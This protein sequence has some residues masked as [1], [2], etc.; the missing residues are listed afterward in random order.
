MEILQTI[1]TALTTPNEGL[2]RIIGIPLNFLEAYI[3]MILFTTI[4]NIESTSKRRLI[5]VLVFGLIGNISTFLIP[6][7]YKIFFTMILWAVL[8]YFILQASLLKSILSEVITLALTSVVDFICAHIFF[9]LFGITSNQIIVIPLYKLLVSITN[10]TIIFLL[11]LIIK[12]FKINI[13]VFD[14]M[15][16]KTKIL[17]VANTVLMIIVIAMQ[18]YIIDFYSD[19]MPTFITFI[20]IL[21]LIAYFAISV[22]SIINSSKLEIASRD[23]EGANL[24]IH[25]LRV[26]HD[27]VRTFKHDFDN[28]VNGIGGYVR[29]NDMEGL[30][31]YYDQ[32]LQDCNKTNNLYSLNPNVIN[33]PAI[34]NILATKYYVADELNVQINLD[35]FLDLNEIEKHMKIYE[36]TRIL[37][38]LLDNAIEAAKECDDKTINVTFRKEDVKHRLIVIIENTYNNKDVNIDEIFEKGI[39]SKQGNSGLGLW[40]IRQILKKNNNLNLFTTKDNKFFKQQFEI[41]Y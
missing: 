10:Y 25:S 34:Y 32:L 3:A 20:S 17:L 36:F 4:L 15:S 21:A 30:T 1:W 9:S 5:Y 13:Q 35:I 39:S 23:L 28:I 11:S 37:G 31:K 38:I 2:L 41:Y 24:T 16:T 29:N 12:Y 18:F 40:K 7:S 22:Y 26:L 27:T 8:V 33:H 6:S 14:N 19:T